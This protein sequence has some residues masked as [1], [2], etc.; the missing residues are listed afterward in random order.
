LSVDHLLWLSAAVALAAF[1]QGTMGVGFALILSP[2][3]GLLEP[4]LLPVGVLVLMLPLN[5]YVALRE[6]RAIDRF[7]AGWITGGR[8]VGTGLGLWV[9]TALTANQLSV[10]VAV[11]ILAAV[12]ATLSVPAFTPGRA[13]FVAAGLIT[14]VTETSTGVGGPP[15]ALALQH[16]PAP[17]L[18]STIAV[19]FFVG[20]VMSLLVLA[21]SGRGHPSD[22]VS[23]CLLLPALAAGAVLSRYLHE[24]V[25]AGFMRGFVLVFATASALV[26]LRRAF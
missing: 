16:Q 13:A 24:R 10:F 11:A 22:F 14:G 2:V 3:V 18:R 6:R 8:V 25:N 23:A 7:G 1:V 20:E 4:A 9:L 17:T 12:A 19:C 21:A 15:L 5:A 26:L